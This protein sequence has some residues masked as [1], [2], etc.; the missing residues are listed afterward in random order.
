MINTFKIL[1]VIMST[2]NLNLTDLSLRTGIRKS[3]LIDEIYVINKVIMDN[4]LPKITLFDNNISVPNKLIKNIQEVFQLFNLQDLTFSQED[5][6]EL[7]ILYIFSHNDYISN[8]HLQ[9]LLNVSKNT[10]LNDISFI[11]AELQEYPIQL[12]YRRSLGYHFKGLEVDIH[13]FIYQVTNDLILN[14]GKEWLILYIYY[15]LEN[16]SAYRDSQSTIENFLSTN[17]VIQLDARLRVVSHC[18]NLLFVRV[19]QNEIDWTG[20]K[21]IEKDSTNPIYKLS[22]CLVTRANKK[23]HVRDRLIQYSYS[24]LLGCFEGDIYSPIRIFYDIANEIVENMESNFLINFESK[25]KLLSGLYRHMI[26][27]YYRILLDYYDNSEHTQLIKNQ[28]K[29][30]FEIVRFSL[31]PLEKLLN[32]KI[33]DSEI[34]YFVVHL[35]SYIKVNTD[36]DKKETL[37]ALVVC[38]NGV[39]S[40]LIIK[41]QLMDIFNNLD[42]RN[43]SSSNIYRTTG[44]NSFDMI[45]STAP[46]ESS[47]PVYNVSVISNDDD[48]VDLMLRVTDDFPEAVTIKSEVYE[49]LNVIEKYTKVE[50]YKKL[51]LSLVYNSNK[52]E[53]DFRKEMPVLSDLITENTFQY[54]SLDLSWKEAI[55]L[56]ASPLLNPKKIEERYIQSMISKVEEFGPFINLG[57]GIAIPHARPEDGVNELSMSMLVLDEP[58]KLLD[59]SDQEVSIL[60]IIAAIDNKLHLEALSHLTTIMRDDEN[61]NVLRNAKEFND[62]KKLIEKD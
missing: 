20:L 23:D 1:S 25:E 3:K 46:F 2:P 29:D 44:N 61:I 37:K 27:A 50:D 43:M 24:L 14:S 18:L 9:E 52:K 35:G 41:H 34:S 58:V 53:K 19:N 36:V 39:S 31:S 10:V 55:Y 56:A 26:P 42:F 21:I 47:I 54:S 17:V 40:S 6:K 4:N 38:P 11:K 45:F 12:K 30:L 62:I 7:I 13:R 15:F 51:K 16:I 60:I 59:Q 28:F 33:P 5:R 32:A 48:I 57:K 22:D 8:L 49:T